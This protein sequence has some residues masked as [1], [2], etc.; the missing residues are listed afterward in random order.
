L[1]LFSVAIYKCRKHCRGCFFSIS[2]ILC[3][4]KSGMTEKGIVYVCIFRKE[5]LVMQDTKK[6]K[7][8]PSFC[9]MLCI[10]PT[11]GMFIPK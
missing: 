11:H 9:Q 8:S 7:V 4:K 1:F 10:E 5:C 6:R 2:R 3:K